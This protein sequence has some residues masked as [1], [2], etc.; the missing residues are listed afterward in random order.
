MIYFFDESVANPNPKEH[1][2][3]ITKNN[4]VYVI[5]RFERS[6]NLLTITVEGKINHDKVNDRKVSISLTDQ[7]LGQ[8]N[9][10]VNRSASVALVDDNN[11]NINAAFFDNLLEMTHNLSWKAEEEEREKGLTDSF[12]S[13]EVSNNNLESK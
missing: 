4:I 13:I 9:N 1:P 7:F 2:N 5:W 8:I 6:P 12:F 10:I 3:F 11:L